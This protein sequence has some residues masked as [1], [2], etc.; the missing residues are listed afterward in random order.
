[1]T[2]IR[3]GDHIDDAGLP[4]FEFDYV[5]N[6]VSVFRDYF[7]NVVWTGRDGVIVNLYSHATRG[8]VGELKLEPRKHWLDEWHYDWHATPSEIRTARREPDDELYSDFRAAFGKLLQSIDDAT[9]PMVQADLV[10]VADELRAA[11]FHPWQDDERG[12]ERSFEAAHN[13]ID[14]LK[15][16]APCAAVADI[17]ILLTKV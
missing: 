14:R 5:R 3:K 7:G 13:A 8:G 4:G 12:D 1:V 9:R 15:R 2:T 6:G 11:I 16:A 10:K 17:L